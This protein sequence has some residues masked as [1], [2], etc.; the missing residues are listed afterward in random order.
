MSLK[1]RR[2]P[3]SVDAQ[4][5]EIYEDLANENEEIRLKA[6]HSLLTRVSSEKS[7]SLE[8]LQRILKRLFRGLASSRKAARLGFSVALTEFLQQHCISDQIDRPVLEVATVI[9]VL[10]EQTRAS[11]GVSGQEERDHYLGRLF[12]AEAII[13]SGILSLPEPP[14]AQWERVLDIIFELAKKKSWLR[15]ECGWVL[16]AALKDLHIMDPIYIEVLFEKL[17]STGLTKTPEGVGLWITAQ[18]AYPDIKYPKHVWHH[19][20]PLHRKETASLARILKETSTHH[21]AEGTAKKTSQRG[22]WTSRLHFSWDVV[23]K[24]L[25]LDRPKQLAFSD[26]W[27]EAVD[28][29]LFAAASS[30]E[31]KYWG[32]LLF[33]KYVQILPI[34]SFG[35]ILGP[36]FLRCMINQLSSAQRYLHR[37]AEKSLRAIHSRIDQD[38]QIT[39]VVIQRF[40]ANG[41]ANFDHLTKTKTVE[42][43]LSQANMQ[44][45]RDIIPIFGHLI[46]RPEAQDVKGASATRQLISDYL[47]SLVRT[48][49]S[50][51]EGDLLWTEYH[52]C[53]FAITTIFLKHAYFE[54]IPDV[55]DAAKSPKPPVSS[56]SREMF[57]S[58]LMS[59]L[60][61]L[62]VKSENS[63]YH[64]YEVVNTIR[65][66]ETQTET[67]TPLISFDKESGIAEIIRKAWKTIKKLHKDEQSADPARTDYLQAFELLYT[68]TILQVYNGDTDA[69]SIIDELQTCFKVLYDSKIP[70]DRGKASETLVEIILSLVSK[71]SLLFKRLAQQVFS[72]CTSAVNANGLQSMMMVLETKENVSGQQEIFEQEDSDG[73]SDVLVSDVEEVDGEIPH[74]GIALYDTAHSPNMSDVGSSLD[75]QFQDD[76][77]DT[78]DD[79]LAEFDA[80]LAQALGTRRLDE[81]LAANEEESSDEDMDDEQME[82]L[83]E[84]LETVFRERKKLTSK[85]N[86]K[87]EAKETIILFKSRVLELLEIYIKQQYLNQQALTI[88]L[89]IL[90]LVQTTSNKQISEKACNLIRDYLK[91]YKLKNR[92]NASVLPETTKLLLE[93]VH[94]E[95]KEE[96]SNAHANACSQASLLLTK[97]YI[98]NGGDLSDVIS[99]YAVTQLA[100]MT[101]P[102]CHIR[103]SFFSDWLNWC[104]SAKKALTTPEFATHFAK[105]RSTNQCPLKLNPIVDLGFSEPIE[106]LGLLNFV[107]HDAPKKEVCRNLIDDDIQ[108]YWLK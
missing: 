11:A 57:K 28:N 59:C 62:M 50:P 85:K 33:Q 12:G 79:E 93:A 21:A 8:E 48:T 51:V 42:K 104:T 87:K 1:R 108:L 35:I 13:K 4:A 25:L 52:R 100:F 19:G 31:R 82:A 54:I 60:S 72:V 67:Y 18:Q 101:E 29:G 88:I 56:G 105:S 49:P 39:S 27:T 47:V 26:L 16:C 78:T 107:P 38:P 81:D 80:K 30:D 77:S 9:N 66:Y 37:I 6:A 75:G 46:H 44:A 98:T 97:I 86:E 68:L 17:H 14:V 45:L 106:A 10:E 3:V 64:P 43:L 102:D 40:I 96:G 103:T 20:N 84:Q 22:T 90:S 83:D 99:Q 65:L 61:H 74:T 24:A 2:E 55:N 23:F 92:L 70:I 5:V 32:F 15:E 34:A 76:N 63:A 7:P 41:Y 89:P 58:R 94:K 95:A 69:V 71:P 91:L 36:N 73:G 53:M